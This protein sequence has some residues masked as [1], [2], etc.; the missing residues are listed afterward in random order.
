MFFYLFIYDPFEYQGCYCVLV[1]FGLRVT[2]DLPSY[3]VT[4]ARDLPFLILN[5]INLIP[6]FIV[7][8][9]VI[10]YFA[11]RIF[12]F[13]PCDI[14]RLEFLLVNDIEELYVKQLMKKK[15]FDIKVSLRYII[16]NIII[17]II[18]YIYITIIIIGKSQ[19]FVIVSFLDNLLFK[20]KN[21]SSFLGS[22]IFMETFDKKIIWNQ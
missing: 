2:I 14:C 1:L 20:I 12:T 15:S 10:S 13:E 8:L 21:F 4:Y 7:N 22:F 6:L 19:N 9:I 5:S 18:T 17:L 11:I 3:V 16:F